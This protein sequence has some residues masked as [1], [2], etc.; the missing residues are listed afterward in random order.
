[1][2]GTW[3]HWHMPHIYR[4]VSLYGLQDDFIVTQTPGGKEDYCTLITGSDRTNISHE[5]EVRTLP[6]PPPSPP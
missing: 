3:I 1:M 6:T 2:G 4:E 5:E